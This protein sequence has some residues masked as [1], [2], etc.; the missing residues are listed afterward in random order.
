M[1]GSIETTECD[2][3]LEKI[4]VLER[5]NA[6]LRDDISGEDAGSVLLKIGDMMCVCEISYSTKTEWR[7]FPETF[8]YVEGKKGTLELGPNYFIRTTTDEG[9][10]LRRIAPPRYDWCDP[11][12]NAIHASMVPLHQ[13][14][15]R[16]FRTGLSPENTGEDNLKTMRLVYAA[17]ESAE[18]NQVITF[19]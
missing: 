19:D 3:L 14:F 4:A 12:Y 2:K 17:Y 16:A 5:E 15:L 7:Q 9:T 11:E 1:S 13:D 6:K 10:Q 18:R 8:V